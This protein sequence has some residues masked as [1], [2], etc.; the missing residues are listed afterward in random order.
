[1]WSRLKLLVAVPV[2]G[3]VCTKLVC[4]PAPTVTGPKLICAGDCEANIASPSSKSDCLLLNFLVTIP[5]L[6]KMPGDLA[7]ARNA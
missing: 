3:S 6:S 7:I 5:P 2:S 1:M 4:N